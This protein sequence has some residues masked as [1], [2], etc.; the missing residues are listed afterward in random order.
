VRKCREW[1]RV[2]VNFVNSPHSVDDAGT[3][4]AEEKPEAITITI[5]I[6][7]K[8]SLAYYLS[9]DWSR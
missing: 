5:T 8:K 6:T 7:I 3:E 1:W 9:S 4:K 2:Y